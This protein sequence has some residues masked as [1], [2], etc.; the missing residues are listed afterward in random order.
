MDMD[1]ITKRLLEGNNAFIKKTN[2]NEGYL[3]RLNEL[4]TK[5]SPSILVFCCS[6]SRVIP[7]Y[8]FNSFFGELFVIR[9]AGN[10]INEGE[11]ASAE[12]ALEHLNIKYVLVLGHTSCGAVHAAIHN[13]EGKF[14]SPILNRIK[15]NVAS[16]CDEREASIINA[17]KEMEYLQDKFSYLNDVTYKYGL[18]DISTREC[19]IY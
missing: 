19:K 6:D 8:I 12:Y 16:V 18:Y 14:L 1:E 4:K 11:L 10:V 3:N 17:R 9:T 15:L 13:E 7:E 2:D 5:Q